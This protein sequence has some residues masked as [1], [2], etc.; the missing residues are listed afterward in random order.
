M[1]TNENDTDPLTTPPREETDPNYPGRTGDRISYG[2]VGHAGSEAIVGTDPN[3]LTALKE[4][5]VPQPPVVIAEASMP[6][7]GENDSI[8][9]LLDGLPLDAALPKK[10]S[11]AAL[12]KA[13][14]PSK[15]LPPVI[16]DVKTEPPQLRKARVDNSTV[17]TPAGLELK[18]QRWVTAGIAVAIG[19]GILVWAINWSA[20]PSRRVEEPEITTTEAV[21]PVKLPP[22]ATMTAVAPPPR[23]TMPEIVENAPTESPSL[24]H[25]PPALSASARSPRP[26]ASAPPPADINDFKPSIRH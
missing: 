16:L 17:V 14:V 20:G 10:A 11:S 25:A 7:V 9:E 18:T 6:P 24:M 15:L 22:A 4:P 8:D 26:P 19:V 2:A 3:F 21:H 12:A 13:A 1:M 5:S 23:V